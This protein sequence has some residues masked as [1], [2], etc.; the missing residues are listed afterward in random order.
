MVMGLLK[1]ATAG[2]ELV[3]VTCAGLPGLRKQVPMEHWRPISTCCWASVGYPLR[4]YASVKTME[5]DVI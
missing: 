4:P 3:M 5:L 2:L 1:P